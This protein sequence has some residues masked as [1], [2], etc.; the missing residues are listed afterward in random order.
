MHGGEEGMETW[1]MGGRAGR[2][3]ETPLPKETLLL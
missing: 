1:R 3:T 2:P